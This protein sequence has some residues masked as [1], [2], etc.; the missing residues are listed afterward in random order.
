M[1]R[2]LI[3]GIII[4]LVILIIIIIILL[5]M[6]PKTDTLVN[7]ETPNDGNLASDLQN[8]SSGDAILDQNLDSEIVDV[9]K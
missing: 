4:A 9:G 2:K 6:G 8:L 7:N 3:L 5:I 1:N